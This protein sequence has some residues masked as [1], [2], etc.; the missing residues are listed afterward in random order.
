MN[1]RAMNWGGMGD[2]PRG[3]AMYHGGGGRSLEPSNKVLRL[4][5]S[6][7]L[8]PDYGGRGHRSDRSRSSYKDRNDRR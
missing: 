3:A 8:H 6:G 2:D 4:D 7:N 5:S 1:Q